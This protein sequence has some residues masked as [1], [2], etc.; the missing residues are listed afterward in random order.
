MRPPVL[1][2]RHFSSLLFSSTRQERIIY[3]YYQT[4]HFFFHHPGPAHTSLPNT[5]PSLSLL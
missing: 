3:S 5:P 2:P 4:N 1:H